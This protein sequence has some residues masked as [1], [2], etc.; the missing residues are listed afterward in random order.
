MNKRTEAKEFAQAVIGTVQESNMHKSLVWAELMFGVTDAMA[1]LQGDD[2]IATVR[3]FAQDIRRR[4]LV[5]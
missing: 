1:D 3:L 2:D 5:D 4:A